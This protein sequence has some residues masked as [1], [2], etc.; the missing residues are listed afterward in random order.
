MTA[1]YEKTVK[2]YKLA[3][4]ELRNASEYL[5][6]AYTS[7]RPLE[8]PSGDVAVSNMRETIIAIEKL[9][10]CQTELLDNMFSDYKDANES[11]E[12]EE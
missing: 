4:E 9:I 8:I 12:E 11:E 1:D 2:A 10:E 6:H 5:Y 7:L 3:L